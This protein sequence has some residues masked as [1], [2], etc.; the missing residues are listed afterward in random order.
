MIQAA[1]ARHIILSNHWIAK[2]ALKR[3]FDKVDKEKFKILF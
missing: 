3:K 1:H 2:L